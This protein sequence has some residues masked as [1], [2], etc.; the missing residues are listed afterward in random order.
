MRPVLLVVAGPNGSRKTTVTQRLRDTHWSHGV[1]YLN[2]DDV[3]QERFGDWNS[4]EASLAAAKWTTNRRE[5]GASI[6]EG[7]M[8]IV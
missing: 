4:P 3:A 5:D 1:E 8:T 2:P 7:W 6:G